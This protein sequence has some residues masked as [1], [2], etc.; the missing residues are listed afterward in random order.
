MERIDW[1]KGV[2]PNPISSNFCVYQTPPGFS[3][4]QRATRSRD[5]RPEQRDRGLRHKSEGIGSGDEF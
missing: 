4:S 2:T 3:K 1:N 5:L